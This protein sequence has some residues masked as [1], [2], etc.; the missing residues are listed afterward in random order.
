MTVKEATAFLLSLTCILNMR[1]LNFS[2]NRRK[3]SLCWQRLL[4]ATVAFQC[5][6]LVTSLELTFWNSYVVVHVDHISITALVWN[7]LIADL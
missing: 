1:F 6:S 3:R 4:L 2:L 7:S 5:L